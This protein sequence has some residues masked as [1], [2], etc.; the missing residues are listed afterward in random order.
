MPHPHY[1]YIL[2]NASK[3]YYVGMTSNMQLRWWQHLHGM[4][5]RHT[6][7][8]HLGRLVYVQEFP[9]RTSARAHERSVKR[10]SRKRKA[11]MIRQHNPHGLDYSVVWGW[12][13][14]LASRIEVGGFGRQA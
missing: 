8:F 13:R 2:T 3:C 5:A 6:Q 10:R 12:R 7:D 14:A 1:V 9:D 4:G 11:A